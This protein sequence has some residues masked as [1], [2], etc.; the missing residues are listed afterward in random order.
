MTIPVSKIPSGKSSIKGSSLNYESKFL[1]KNVNDNFNKKE[2][3]R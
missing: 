1:L 2:E 3:Q